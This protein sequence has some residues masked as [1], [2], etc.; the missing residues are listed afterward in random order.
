[1]AGADRVSELVVHFEQ[2]I[3]SG[4]LAPGDLLPSERSLSVELGVSRSVVREALGRLASMGLVRSQH[5][6]GTRVEVPSGQQ[7]TAAYQRLLSLSEHA[8]DGEATDF[9]LF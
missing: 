5:G 7:V 6:S 4:T 8:R 3:L 2:Q 1:M 9:R